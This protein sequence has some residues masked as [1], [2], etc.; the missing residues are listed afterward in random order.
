[1]DER[2]TR[3][4]T[5]G[6]ASVEGWLNGTAAQL[7]LTMGSIQRALEVR[8]PVCEIG[9]HHGRTFVL[10]HLL[11]KVDELSVAYDLYELQDP[12]IGTERKRRLVANVAQHGGEMTTVRVITT[13]SLDLT[14]ARVLADC[15]GEPRIFSID[16]ARTAAATNHDLALAA[17]SLCEGGIVSVTDHFSEVWPEVSEGVN[18]FMVAR[19]ELHPVA[20]G[21][22][23]Y[24]FAKSTD[25][26]ARCRHE[27]KRAFSVQAAEVIAFGQPVVVI[28]PLTPRRRISRSKA[29]QLVRHTALGDV[30]R[31]LGRRL[32]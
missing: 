6:Y 24:F 26:A 18:Q 4:A 12:A 23:K 2:S 25:F 7:Y 19:G 11:T 5:R 14:R 22:N 30:L 3:Y 32:R 1:M 8:G 20:I 16:G 31:T 21:G 10:L 27:I 13:D 15:G 28:R 29:W 17:Q 9:V